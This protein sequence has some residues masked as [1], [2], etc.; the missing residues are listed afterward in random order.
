MSVDRRFEIDHQNTLGKF[1]E[2]LAKQLKAFTA[3]EMVG[4]MEDFMEG[5][6]SSMEV[7]VPERTLRTKKS[8]YSEVQTNDGILTIDFGHDKNNE[9]DYVPFIYMGLNPE[10]EDISFR[11]ATATPYWLDVAVEENLPKLNSK[12]SKPRGK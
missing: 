9:L 1:S 2:D 8:W 11:K 12:M 10:G 5:V 6:K 3:E 7:Y 4:A